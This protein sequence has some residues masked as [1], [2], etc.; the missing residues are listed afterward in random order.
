MISNW[1]PT[2]RR[3]GEERKLMLDR[4][5]LPRSWE[6]NSTICLPRQRP[7][8]PP[9]LGNTR[10][11]HNYNM[12]VWETSNGGTDSVQSWTNIALFAQQMSAAKCLSTALLVSHL[13]WHKQ[14]TGNGRQVQQLGQCRL[15]DHNPPP[16]VS[17]VSRRGRITRAHVSCDMLVLSR[18]L[19]R[20]SV[21]RHVTTSHSGPRVV[22]SAWHAPGLTHPITRAQPSWQGMPSSLFH[23]IVKCIFRLFIRSP[24][25]GEKRFAM[26]FFV[27][28]RR[29]C[30]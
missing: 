25:C 22:T 10:S 6:R 19:W 9:P 21:T 15:P 1:T 7:Y 26:E 30:L 8:W 20:G 12:P 14:R 3:R 16:R 28:M 23:N 24:A 2:R 4:M 27:N 18:V 29:L 13:L 17:W 11:H 5:R